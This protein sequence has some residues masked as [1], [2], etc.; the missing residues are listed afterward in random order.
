MV[1]ILII[2]YFVQIPTD[3]LVHTPGEWPVLG[4]EH[5][6][7]QLSVITYMGNINNIVSPSFFQKFYFIISLCVNSNSIYLNYSLAPND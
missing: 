6:P 7:V 4:Y 5:N 1:F 3:V 2:V